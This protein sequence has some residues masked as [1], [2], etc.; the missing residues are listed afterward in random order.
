MLTREGGSRERICKDRSPSLELKEYVRS[1]IEVS[2]GLDYFD[3]GV[4][5]LFEVDLER[6]RR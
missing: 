4:R 6:G 3:G 1:T 2:R 5:Q